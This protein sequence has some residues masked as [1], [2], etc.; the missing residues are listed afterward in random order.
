MACMSS[1]MCSS[2]GG[3]VD[4]PGKLPMHP[5]MYERREHCLPPRQ[6]LTWLLPSPRI[7]K[8]SH[9]V[10]V[11]AANVHMHKSHWCVP[12]RLFVKH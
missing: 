10:F 7:C 6:A 8:C 11:D 9:A 2:M 12:L 3:H 4:M 5:C 1:N